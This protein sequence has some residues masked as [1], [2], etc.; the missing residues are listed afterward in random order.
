VSSAQDA[1]EVGFVGSPTIR[2]DGT[3]PFESRDQ[4]TD[5][6]CRVYVEH[7]VRSGLPDLSRLGQA[8]KRH[9][10]IDRTK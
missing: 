8:L 9:A 2:I 7:G 3:D 4:P 6:A 5:F 1:E 10:E